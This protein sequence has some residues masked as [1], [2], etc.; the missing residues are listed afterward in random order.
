[1]RHPK[2]P[3][4]WEFWSSELTGDDAWR[5]AIE[6]KQT[7]ERVQN[8]VFVRVKVIPAGGAYWILRRVESRVKEKAA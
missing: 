6:Y 3:A 8:S 5:A 1:M 7:R 2:I 4:G